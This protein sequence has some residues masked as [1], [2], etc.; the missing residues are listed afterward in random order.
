MAINLGNIRSAGFRKGLAT[1]FIKSEA[2]K[3]DADRREKEYQQLLAREQTN[4][5]FQ[6]SQSLLSRDASTEQSRLGREQTQ[7]NFKMTYDRENLRYATTL[8]K[9]KDALKAVN[10]KNNRSRLTSLVTAMG[11]G[12]TPES[13]PLLQQQFKILPPNEIKD[14]VNATMLGNETKL[15]RDDSIKLRTSDM[16][17]F[18]Q[19]NEGDIKDTNAINTIVSPK[20][21]KRMQEYGQGYW[22]EP[23]D[24]PL[25]V[26]D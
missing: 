16:S 11:D 14:L 3:A 6:A 24:T 17:I 19:L 5:D 4:R 25:E 12:I 2:A 23:G 20:W 1:G 26:L 22:W 10:I 21:F 13:I 8:K 18:K 15:S 7:S 9:E